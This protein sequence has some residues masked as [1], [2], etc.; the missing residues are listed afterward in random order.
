LKRIANRPVI[1]AAFISAT[2]SA[3]ELLAQ[4]PPPPYM[5]RQ[6]DDAFLA[7][8][9]SGTVMFTVTAV[10]IVL[11]SGLFPSLFPPRWLSRRPWWRMVLT[12]A[13]I[14]VGASLL[15]V[16]TPA[17]QLG[18]WAYGGVDPAYRLC[19]EKP[20]GAQ[21]L[22]AGAIGAGQPALSQKA[23]LVFLIVVAV[24]IGSV[25]TWV[26]GRIKAR[27]TFNKAV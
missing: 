23:S 10:L 12:A 8:F 16:T 3:R 11:L 4:G 13:T 27:S 21:G 19:S 9:Y 7:A 25:V 22:L 1:T 24:S 14:S 6:W 15:L 5:C 20:F 18:A 26:V 17:Y 2:W